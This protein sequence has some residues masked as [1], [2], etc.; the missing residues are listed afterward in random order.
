MKEKNLREALEKCSKN[1]LI[2]AIVKS[3]GMTRATLPWLKI[4]AEIRLHEIDEK[5][6]TNLAESEKLTH[7][8]SEMAKNPHNYTNDEVL[9][10]RIALVKNHKEWEQLN[11]KHDKIC[12]ELYG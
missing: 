11:R 12:N 2:E 3:G 10:V 1:E 4:I 7:K 9:K 8:F 5:I 6:E